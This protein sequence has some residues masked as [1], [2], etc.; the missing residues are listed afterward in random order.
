MPRVK[1]KPA[2]DVPEIA[3]Q[4]MPICIQAMADQVGVMIKENWE[5]IKAC[6]MTNPDTKVKLAFG[7]TLDLLDLSAVMATIRLRYSPRPFVDERI[8]G[9][10][11]EEDEG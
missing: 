1:K 3:D 4:E 5:Q 10:G 6:A 7:M 2:M 9:E 8:V 11:H